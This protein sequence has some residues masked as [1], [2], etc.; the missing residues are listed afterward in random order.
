[1]VFLAADMDKARLIRPYLNPNIPV[2]GTSQLFRGNSDAL[3]N[4]D[5]NE[6][7]FIDMPWLLQLDHPAVMIYPH[8]IP[9]L[10]IDRE[11]L[12]A[13]GIDAYRLIQVMLSS[14]LEA[15]L[16]LDGVTGRISMGSN[17]QLQRE[18]VL[19]LFKL[20]RGLTP[21]A[22]AAI[23]AAKAAEK[24]AERAAAKAAAENADNALTP[25]A[26]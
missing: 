11:R 20:G 9:P 26:Q 18:P 25:P 10:D 19:A 3:V 12:Y 14:K 24:A 21:E 23:N 1:M 4:Y 8:A 2:Y 5:L 17:N 15:A 22:L 13:L 6:I 7:R 16:P